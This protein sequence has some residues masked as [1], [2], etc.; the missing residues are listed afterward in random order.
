[1]LHGEGIPKAPGRLFC[2]QAGVKVVAG[3]LRAHCSHSMVQSAKCGTVLRREVRPDRASLRK[4]ISK[5]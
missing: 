4:N 5:A 1:M 3:Q 2:S